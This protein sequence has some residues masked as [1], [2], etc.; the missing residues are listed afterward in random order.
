[1]R[2]IVTLLVFL[3]LVALAAFFGAHFQP[4]PWFE[5]L[6]KPSWNPPNWVF[7]PVWT[8]LYLGMAVAGW[9]VWKRSGE[10]VT[11]VLVVWFVQL[12][13]NAAWSWLFFG[14]HRPPLALV[15]ILALLACIVAFAILARRISPA[16]SWLFVPYALWV[17]F[18]TVLN[19]TIWRL[20]P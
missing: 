9:L 5:G 16:A 20:N 4:G 19:A 1:M 15:D 3:A 7:G 12:G 18:A 17:S 11:P 14:L 8:L 6:A 10:H 13:L 2:S